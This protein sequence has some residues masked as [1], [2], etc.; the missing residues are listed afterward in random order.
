MRVVVQSGEKGLD[1]MRERGSVPI[2]SQSRLVV[3]S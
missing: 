2:F 3:Y 1:E